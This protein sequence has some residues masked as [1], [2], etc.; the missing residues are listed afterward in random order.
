LRSQG[1]GRGLDSHAG[2]HQQSGPQQL[3]W[4]RLLAEHD[5]GEQGGGEGFAQRQHRGPSGPDAPQ[6]S[7]EQQGGGR[8]GQGALEQKQR[9]EPEIGDRHQHGRRPGHGRQCAEPGCRGRHDQERRR[10]VADLTPPVAAEQDI[11]GVQDGRQQGQEEPGG[12]D[13][14]QRIRPDQQDQPDDGHGGHAHARAGADHARRTPS[15]AGLPGRD[16][17]R[18]AA[19]CGHRDG[20]R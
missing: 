16:Q 3:R 15:R 7:Q 13:R 18:V 6:A 11:S 10:A 9:G 8:A 14:D 5:R 17:Q 12:G 1:G 19:E 2:A 20:H 4:G